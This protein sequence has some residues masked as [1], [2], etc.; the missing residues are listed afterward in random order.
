[1][2][3][4][5]LTFSLDGKSNKNIKAAKNSGILEPCFAT[6]SN[7]TRFHRVS[8]SDYLLKRPSL[9]TAFQNLIRISWMPVFSL[10]L[11]LPSG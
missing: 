10:D 6:Q 2:W 4:V 5:R 8:D 3:M 9:K 11:N 1:M 7:S